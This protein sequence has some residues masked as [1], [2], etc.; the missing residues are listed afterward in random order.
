MRERGWEAASKVCAYDCQARAMRLRWWEQPPCVAS[1]RGKDRAAKLLRRMLR[2]GISRWHQHPDPPHSAR[3]LRTRSHGP[4]DGRTERPE[5]FAPPHMSNSRDRN[6]ETI[7]LRKPRQWL[8]H[9][10]GLTADVR[11]GQNAKN[12]H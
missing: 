10:V 6:G 3:L 12:S 7:A 8:H 9:V 1:T 5:K 4:C 11:V 2:R